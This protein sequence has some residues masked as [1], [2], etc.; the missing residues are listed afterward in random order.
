M[1]PPSH[2]LQLIALIMLVHSLAVTGHVTQASVFR[3]ASV[4]TYM[5]VRVC[6]SVGGVSERVCV[7]RGT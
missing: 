7:T 1:G 6:T 2:R 3:W 4:V 5:S